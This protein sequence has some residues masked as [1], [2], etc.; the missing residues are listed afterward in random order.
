MHKLTVKQQKFAD[1]YII[2]GNATQA[3]LKAGYSKHTATQMGA[4]NLRK[5]YLMNYI[6][7][8]LKRL[9][10]DRVDT[11]EEIMEFL[12]D[13][14]RGKVTESVATAR[15]VYDNV[16]VSVRDRVKAAEL[17]GKR[18]AMWT[19]KRDITGTIGP[20]EISDDVPA[21]SDENG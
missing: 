9:H 8:Q 4:E 6:Q 10:D 3:A 5:P 11:Q 16:P 1:E 13:V 2:S 19:E 15:G 17:I 18:Y 12:S 14:R 7:A 21:G 20:V